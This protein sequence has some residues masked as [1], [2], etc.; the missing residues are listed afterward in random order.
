MFRR[1][2]DRVIG[3]L[4]RCSRGRWGGRG[5]KNFRGDFREGRC[6][7]LGDSIGEEMRVG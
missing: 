2:G 1:L 5:F 7:V 3:D 4:L 6:D